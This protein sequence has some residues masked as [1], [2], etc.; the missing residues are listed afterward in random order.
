VIDTTSNE[1]VQTIS[2]AGGV[3]IRLAFTPDGKRVLA[4]DAKAGDVIVFDAES[5]KETSRV[6]VGEVPVGITVSNDGR[7]AFVATTGDGRVSCM[8]LTKLA[9]VG[10]LE[11]GEQPDGVAWVEPR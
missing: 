7:R 1:I 9:V 2:C 10:S 3:P 4:S 11:V 5:F 8:D 6:H